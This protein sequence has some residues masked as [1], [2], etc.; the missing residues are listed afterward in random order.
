MESVWWQGQ[1]L[2]DGLLAVRVESVHPQG[3][4]VLCLAVGL[5]VVQQAGWQ[6]PA[7]RR[8]RRLGVRPPGPG[9][10]SVSASMLAAFRSPASERGCRCDSVAGYSPR[11]L[12]G[13]ASV[14]RGRLA[15]RRNGGHAEARVCWGTGELPIRP[16]IAGVAVPIFL[17]AGYRICLM[18]VRYAARD[19]VGRPVR[20]AAGRKSISDAA[21]LH[22]SPVVAQVH[23]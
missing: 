14:D 17:D 7:G 13:R 16:A 22:G 10:A 3:P 15:R 12:P 18:R 20:S 6:R 11:L 19:R 4:R 21:C 1:V 8:R 9:R 5:Q 23:G 2:R